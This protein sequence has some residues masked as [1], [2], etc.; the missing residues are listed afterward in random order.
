MNIQD[1]THTQLIDWL[2]VKSPFSNEEIKNELKLRHALETQKLHNLIRAA[3][4]V[5]G[6][7]EIAHRPPVADEI[8]IGRMV[9]VRLH[10]LAQLYTALQ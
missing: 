8:E 1:A 2:G 9:N 7:T 6:W 4:E 5:V 3:H 10:A